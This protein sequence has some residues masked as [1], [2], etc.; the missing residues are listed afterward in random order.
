M[1]EVNL[2]PNVDFKVLSEDP[3][4]KFPIRAT[5]HS[6]GYDLFI[7]ESV[8]LYPGDVKKVNMGFAIHIR[9]SNIAME[10]MPRSG[11]GTKGLVLGNLIGLIDADYQG[12][13]ICSLW[14]RS[15]E[16][17]KF[18]KGDKVVQMIFVPIAHPQF[19]LVDE[20]EFETGRGDGGF[21]HTDTQK[22]GEVP[23]L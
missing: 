10:I 6:A 18:D 22:S 5:E 3:D 8:S 7:P 13:V 4:F 12:P 11:L 16:M 21:G 2:S 14:N 20:F 1:T 19:R 9:D 15:S 17:M 23:I